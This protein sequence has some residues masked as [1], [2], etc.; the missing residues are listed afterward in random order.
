MPY[1][2]SLSGMRKYLE[3]EMLAP[4]LRGRVRYHCGAPVEGEVGLFVVYVDDHPVR[5][6]S[7]E[8]MARALY[9]GEKPTDMAQFWHGY[10]HAAEHVHAGARDVHDEQEF[11]GALRAY[12]MSDIAAALRSDDPNVRMLAL[13]DRRV[14]KRTLTRMRDEVC[15]WPMWLRAFYDLRAAAEGLP[16]TEQDITGG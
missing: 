1:E 14:G 11:A 4:A 12:R 3:Q 9:Q 7:M 6:Y 13:L 15:D 8:S 5:R 2:K 16:T 10:W